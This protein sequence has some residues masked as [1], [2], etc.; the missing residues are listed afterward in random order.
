MSFLGFL[1]NKLV[2]VFPWPLRIRDIELGRD[3]MRTAYWLY[4]RSPCF[5]SLDDVGTLISG[6]LS[7]IAR[8]PSVNFVG[9]EKYHNSGSEIRD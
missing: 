5:L 6:N 7:R 9:K 3:N 1:G 2:K 4:Q 8:L